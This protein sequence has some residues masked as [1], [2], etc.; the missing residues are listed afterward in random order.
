MNNP[1]L[2]LTNQEAKLIA[3]D[4]VGLA[5]NQDKSVLDVIDR[6][7]TLQMDSVNVFERAHY[8]PLFSRLGTYDKNELDSLTQGTKPRLIEYWAHQASY[9][10]PENLHLYE[11]RMQYYRDRAARANSFDKENAKLIKWIFDEIKNNGPMTSAQFEHQDNQRKGSWW[12]W[13][14]VKRSLESQFRQCHLIGAGRNN[15]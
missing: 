15:F 6:F 2:S 5:G 14:T 1:T 8:M 12:G 13:S 3:L 4:A 11:W 7:G 9:I 10:R